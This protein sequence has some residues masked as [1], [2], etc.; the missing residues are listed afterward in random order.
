MYIGDFTKSTF[1]QL[2]FKFKCNIHSVELG[3]SELRRAAFES[4]FKNTEHIVAMNTFD[5]VD[6][7][8]FHESSPM[9]AFELMDLKERMFTN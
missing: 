7:M 5:F 8:K 6:V 9:C 1:T 3:K 2:L 4:T